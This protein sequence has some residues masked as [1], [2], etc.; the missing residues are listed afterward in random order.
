MGF[1][2]RRRTRDE[3]FVL[4]ARRAVSEDPVGLTDRAGLEISAFM[5]KVVG[6]PLPS[7]PYMGV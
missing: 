3:G 4:Y 2:Y 1:R 7:L 5:A 6:K